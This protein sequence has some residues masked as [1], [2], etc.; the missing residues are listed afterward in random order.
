[1]DN[2][3]PDFAKLERVLKGEQDP[4]RV[5]V[6][7]LLIDDEVL[8][9]ITTFILDE[10]WSPRTADAQDPYFQQLCTVYYR[11]GY[12]YVPIVMWPHTWK[13]H[14]R[15]RIRR[16]RDTAVLSRGEREWVDQ[17]RGLV[18]SLEEF[19]Q[20]PWNKIQP[21]YA[22]YE[23]V[24]RNLPDGMRIIAQSTLFE[25]VLERVL[26]YEGIFYLLVDNQEL[27]GEVF[28]RWGQKL[29]EFYESV[30]SMEEVGAIWHA[31]DLGYRTSCLV[32]PDV[33][34][35]HVFPWFKKYAALAHA[36]GK[37]FW[38]H[39]C[40]N[41]FKPGIIEDF[42]EDIG[43]DAFHS[44]QDTIMHVGDFKAKY[45]DRVATLGGVDM[46][47]L[48]RLDEARLRRYIRDIL[49]RCVP[50]GRYALGSGNSIANYVPLQNYLT[51]LEEARR[52]QP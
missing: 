44:F 22:P 41:H 16:A 10:P 39:S 24:A 13:N 11:M 2:P 1:L 27:V 50:G 5:H 6:V 49:E 29:Y 15:P 45:G 35:Q 43:I 25:H 28:S 32:S 14:P 51:M 26:G 42:I 47:Q 3:D 37:T 8:R 48:A 20:F 38:L 52:W 33:L 17:S 4:D 46:D 30:V 19:D 40:G 36:H 34:R 31:D 21:D 18:S 12:D 7:E 23:V 9:S